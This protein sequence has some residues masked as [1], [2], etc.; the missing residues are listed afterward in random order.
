MAKA[1]VNPL[2]FFREARAKYDEGGPTPAPVK[3]NAPSGNLYDSS[4][5]KIY[6]N[7]RV[8]IL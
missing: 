6:L 7:P 2:T 5:K 1:K 4:G 8:V 3:L